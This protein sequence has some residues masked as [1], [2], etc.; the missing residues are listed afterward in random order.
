[1][2]AIGPG[3]PYVLNR[4]NIRKQNTVLLVTAMF[5][6]KMKLDYLKTLGS[7]RYAPTGKKEKLSARGKEKILVGYDVDVEGY[8]LWDKTVNIVG[9]YCDVVFQEKSSKTD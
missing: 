1:V 2:G 4:T 3:G 7:F 8:F 6:R 5:G 9:T